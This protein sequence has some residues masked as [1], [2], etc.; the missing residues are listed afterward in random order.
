MTI[1]RMWPWIANCR[2]RKFS[3]LR[4]TT[5]ER[6][7]RFCWRKEWRLLTWSRCPQPLKDESSC[8]TCWKITTLHI[9][10]QSSLLVQKPAFQMKQ[11]LLHWD[12]QLAFG[13]RQKTLRFRRSHICN[14]TQHPW[15]PIQADHRRVR[16]VGS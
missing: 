5:F 7:S 3:R 14:R 12:L 8:V 2:W 16:Q 1:W 13:S 4:L 6:T 10:N 11:L 15:S 9:L